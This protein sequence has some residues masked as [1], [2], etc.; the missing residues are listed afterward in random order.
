MFAIIV[1]ESSCLVSSTR[2]LLFNMSLQEIFPCCFKSA[3][4][5]AL[6]LVKYGEM[7]HQRSILRSK[8]PTSSAICILVLISQ[9]AMPRQHTWR[10]TPVTTLKIF[11]SPGTPTSHVFLLELQK[12]PLQQPSRRS[13]DVSL[14]SPDCAVEKYFS[15]VSVVSLQNPQ[16]SA[17]GITWKLTLVPQTSN[18]RWDPPPARNGKRRTCGSRSK[19]GPGGS[20]TW[21]ERVP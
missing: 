20:T 6:L 16:V 15:I 3:Q 13:S 10:I 5:S 11:R 18:R 19:R 4:T 17:A 9:S 7:P 14:C 8:S 12:T 21:R 2:R 1:G